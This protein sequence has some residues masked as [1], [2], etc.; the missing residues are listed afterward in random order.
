MAEAA[1]EEQRRLN[2]EA[3]QEEQ[4]RL[5]DEG[6]QIEQRRLDDEGAQIERR[7]IREAQMERRIQRIKIIQEMADIEREREKGTNKLKRIGRQT[8]TRFNF[9]V[10]EELYAGTVLLNSRFISKINDWADLLVT[11]PEGNP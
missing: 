9:G 10:L 8:I 11:D 1:Q 2:D 6:A 7:L 4:R 3:A 5:N